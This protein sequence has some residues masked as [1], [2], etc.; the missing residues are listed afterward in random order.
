VI[1]RIPGYNFRDLIIFLVSFVEPL[2]G[3]RI[4]VDWGSRLAR[5][6]HH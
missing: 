2:A 4:L 6:K 1:L 5:G 3:I